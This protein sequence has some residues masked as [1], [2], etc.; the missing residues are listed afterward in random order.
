MPATN[1]PFDVAIITVERFDGDRIVERWETY[2]R[3][4]LMA[5]LMP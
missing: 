3:D 4:D 2:D 5:Q 1:R